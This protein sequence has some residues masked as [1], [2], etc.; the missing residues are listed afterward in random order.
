VSSSTFPRKPAAIALQFCLLNWLVPGAGYMAAGDYKRGSALFV[1]INS[2]LIG[3]IAYGGYVVNP[4]W[5]FR[6]SDFNL[7]SLLTF[8]AQAFHGGGWLL[9]QWIE[10]SAAGNAESAFN[11]QNLAIKPF[12]DLGV[13][14]LV[15][16]GGLNYFATM[17]LYDLMAGNPELTESP[18]TKASKPA[19]ADA[20]ASAQE[21]S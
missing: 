9:L 18:K 7:V 2:I 13:F 17:R 3:G 5:N 15:V 6:A 20:D 12:S 11:I 1:I 21:G 14:H 19:P 4:Q 16:A 8:I 10:A